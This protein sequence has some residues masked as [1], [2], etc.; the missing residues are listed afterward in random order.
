MSLNDLIIHDLSEIE[1]YF[2]DRATSHFVGVGYVLN[3]ESKLLLSVRMIKKSFKEAAWDLES[4]TM[5]IARESRE[6]GADSPVDYGDAEK[7][8][9]AILERDDRICVHWRSA[10]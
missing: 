7:I 6:E 1:Q 5:A 9:R 8:A 2:S 10:V 4:L 3:R